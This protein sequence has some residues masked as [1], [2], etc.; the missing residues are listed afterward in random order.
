VEVG[1]APGGKASHAAMR[2]GPTG[3]IIAIDRPAGFK[4]TMEEP[5][6]ELTTDNPPRAVELLRDTAGV[7]TA[8]M[9]GRAVHIIVQDETTTHQQVE[10]ELTT[11]GLACTNLE[12]IAPS[13]EDVFVSLVMREGGAVVG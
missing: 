13:L 11:A 2:T 1:A 12:R 3:R 4:S 9:F 5:I 7:V 8:A 6:F 10:R